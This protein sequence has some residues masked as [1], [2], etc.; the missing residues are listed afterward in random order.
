MNSL[1]SLFTSFAV[2]VVV[3]CACSLACAWVNVQDAPFNAAGDGVTDDTNAIQAAL[4]TGESVYLP[5]GTYR[6]TAP[7]DLT[8]HSS[9]GTIVFGDSWAYN[10]QAG[11]VVLG[12]TG[13]VV[14]DCTGSQFLT[15]KNLTVKSG[16]TDASTC[17]FLFARSS[18]S[19]YAQ[20]NKMENVIVRIASNPNAYG[21]KGTVA[22]Y[23]WA[24]EMMHITDPYFSADTALVVTSSNAWSIT[25]SYVNHSTLTSTSQVV[26]D[27]GNAE[28]ESVDDGGY[29]LYL[30]GAVSCDFNNVYFK[31]DVEEAHEAAIK[32]IGCSNINITGHKELDGPVASL[33]NTTKSSSIRISTHVGSQSPFVADSGYV[34]I[35][36]MD[37][38]VVATDSPTCSYFYNSA[39]T[40]SITGCKF[41]ANWKPSTSWTQI[42]GNS[43]S[44]TYTTNGVAVN[45]GESS[46]PGSGYHRIGEIVYNSAPATGQYIGWVCTA[47]GTPGTWKPFGKID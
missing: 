24:A 23:N 32:M 47:S 16:Q 44:C 39:Y 6:V 20:F 22:V 8:D 37:L 43:H 42:T 28:L 7:L 5:V 2:L 26:L 15:F 25:S 31:G 41:T 45:S 38:S 14:F 21:G 46:Y 9:G 3:L 19:Q 17:G 10:G 33:G 36:N 35:S 1:K 13:G 18:G 4:D 30:S 11:T 12:E 27:G 29:C 34:G 40:N